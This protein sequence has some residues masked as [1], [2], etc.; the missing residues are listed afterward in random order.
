M[1]QLIRKV[2]TGMRA[3]PE[4]IQELKQAKAGAKQADEIIKAEVEEKT[5]LREKLKKAEEDRTV[6]EWKLVEK[7]Q[8]VS[9]LKESNKR[10]LEENDKLN[11]KL[12]ESEEIIKNKDEEQKVTEEI[13]SCLINSLRE[14]KDKLVVSQTDL[15]VKLFQTEEIIKSENKKNLAL[16]EAL[17]KKE[18]EHNLTKEQLVQQA[19]LVSNLNKY[20][21]LLS[22]KLF[23]DEEIIK[24]EKKG[25]LALREKLKKMEE[26]LTIT[27][28][29]LPEKVVS[30]LRYL[31][32][33][34]ILS[35]E[36]DN[37][38]AAEAELAEKRMNWRQS[39]NSSSKR[40]RDKNSDLRLQLQA[41]RTIDLRTKLT[42]GD[43]REIVSN[44][45]DSDRLSS[46]RD[47]K[48][49]SETELT[50]NR[51][52]LSQSTNSS[53]RRRQSKNLDLRLQLLAERDSDLN[54]LDRFSPDRDDVTGSETQLA[55]NRLNWSQSTNSSN[56]GMQNKNLDLRLQLLAERDIDRRRNLTPGGAPRGHIPRGC[57]RSSPL[58]STSSSDSSRVSQ[59]QL[60]S[61]FETTS[62]ERGAKRRESDRE[63][64]DRRLH[65]SRVKPRPRSNK[66][67]RDRRRCSPRRT[68]YSRKKSRESPPRGM[69]G[70]H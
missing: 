10:L 33:Y 42:P 32:D 38:A 27:K 17:E 34:D 46:E 14:E 57:G 66:R 31:S 52:N 69:F 4:L 65:K 54:D 60:D 70:N 15:S 22:H 12:V 19:Q 5:V 25:N 44:L 63:R 40:L 8:M 48:A 45:N 61:D 18:E 7:D 16:R 36:W 21:A 68:P 6:S 2:S 53:N 23:N 29:Q 64:G 28:E 39:T 59:S 24:E 47:N 62:R 55:E 13:V 51:L 49:A 43:A 35:A 9:N 50:E 26:E 41:E 58:R 11:Q 3:L 20:Q 30:G 67:G 37:M 56:Q 1:G